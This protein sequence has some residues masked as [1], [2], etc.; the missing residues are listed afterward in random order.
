M[1]ILVPYWSFRLII[2]FLC[3]VI[4]SYMLVH[5]KFERHPYRLYGIDLIFLAAYLINF[6]RFIVDFDLSDQ[7][8]VMLNLVVHMVNPAGSVDTGLKL[9]YMRSMFYWGWSFNLI[10]MQLFLIFNLILNWDMY[11]MM[12]N[13]FKPPRIRVN[14]YYIKAAGIALFMLVAELFFYFFRY[15]MYSSWIQY[16]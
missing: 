9:Q 2:G 8:Y 6:R 1:H 13:P 5:K 12:K 7:Y 11:R 16:E 14:D 4:G 10:C 15:V 3:L